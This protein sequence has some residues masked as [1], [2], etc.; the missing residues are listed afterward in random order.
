MYRTPEL[1]VTEKF[2]GDDGTRT[3]DLMRDRHDSPGYLIDFAA[4][5]ATVKHAKA[6]L[7]RSSGTQMVPVFLSYFVG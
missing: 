1:E 7:E 3:R 4:R 5:L 2:G 6:P